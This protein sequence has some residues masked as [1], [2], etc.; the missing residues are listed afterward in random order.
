M[1]RRGHAFLVTFL[2]SQKR[3]VLVNMMWRTSTTVI[4]KVARLILVLSAANILE[5][6]I[7]GQYSYLLSLVSIA[8][9]FTGWGIGILLVRD[10]QL[11]Q[12]KNEVFA[13]A[14]V[15]KLLIIIVSVLIALGIGITRAPQFVVPCMIIMLTIGTSHVRDIF[16]NVF[17]GLQKTKY[18]LVVILIE[19]SVLLGG[20]FLWFVHAPSLAHLTMLYVAA[21]GISL[22][23]AYILSQKFVTFHHRFLKM[24]HIKMFL[25]NGFPLSLFGITS[26]LFFSTDQVVLHWFRGDYE[27]GIYSFAARIILALGALP[28]LINT[29]LLPYLSRYRSDKIVIK[30]II[31]YGLGLLNILAVGLIT[32]ICLVGPYFI[33]W[34]KPQYLDS[35]PLLQLSSLTLLLTFTVSGM[36]FQCM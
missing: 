30:R 3:E 35:L 13:N 33:R 29:V 7:F 10:L 26:Y 1:I 36:E 14:L 4:D 6:S 31:R 11:S 8:F 27:T 25:K 20:F 24:Q 16:I 23:V 34:F 18:E 28:S 17:L 5:P 15:V 2:T 19:D 21:M 9:I 32:G 12:N 22:V